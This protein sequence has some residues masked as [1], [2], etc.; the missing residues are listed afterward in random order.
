MH[1]NAAVMIAP[2]IT[3]NIKRTGSVSFIRF[4]LRLYN[5]NLIPIHFTWPVEMIKA[6]LCDYV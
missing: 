5:S 6:V 1:N 2:H 4:L 3:V